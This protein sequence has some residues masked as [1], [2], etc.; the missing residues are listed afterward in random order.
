M[1]PIPKDAPD[2]EMSQLETAEL[3]KTLTEENPAILEAINERERRVLELRFG[4][5]DGK[6]RTLEQVGKEVGLVSR[7]RVRQIQNCAIAKLRRRR[8]YSQKLKSLSCCPEVTAGVTGNVKSTVGRNPFE[9]TTTA[10]AP[11]VTT[12][13]DGHRAIHQA[14]SPCQPNP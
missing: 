6:E 7:E 9:K 13:R 4:L 14:Y 12:G 2:C 8:L 11:K 3:W 10:A 1:Q 5:L